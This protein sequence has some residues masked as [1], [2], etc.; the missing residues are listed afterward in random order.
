MN[1]LKLL[2]R[3]LARNPRR[4]LLT[5]LGLVVSFFVYTSLASI[6]F[7]LTQM[8]ERT[9]SAT[10]L[11]LRPKFGIRFWRAEIPLTYL[12]KIRAVPGVV[13]LTPYDFFL[14]EGKKKGDFDVAI[15]VDPATIA[16]VR[17]LKGATSAELTAFAAER[18]GA[19]V[20]ERLLEN[21]R[22][23]LGGEITMRNPLKGQNLPVRIRGSLDRDGDF[24]DVLLVHNDYLQDVNGRTGKTVFVIVKVARPDL[25]VSVAR[26]IDEGFKNFTVPTETITEKAFTETVI[27]GL[28][29]TLQALTVIG[30]L[31]LGV[32][33]LVVANT[34]AMSVRE[35]TTEIGTLRALG[36]SSRRVLGLV[37]GEASLVSTIGGLGGA[38]LAWAVFHYQWIKLPEEVGLELHTSW[39]V[40]ARAAV[41]ALPIGAL[42]GLKPAWDAS[43]M[44]I[45]EALRHAD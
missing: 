35:R 10:T 36:F 5:F 19:L 31:T 37:V 12:P 39:Q 4:T 33:M 43:R 27:G 17:D 14:G 30:Y 13:A 42:A 26:T 6:L 34:V 8:I 28:A 20:G 40:V 32:T 25:A 21:N 38:L 3:G 24:G 11:F 18:S 15:G 1:A 2:V 7:T 44:A 29:D 23:R 9:G 41:L 16:Q 22:W 45:T